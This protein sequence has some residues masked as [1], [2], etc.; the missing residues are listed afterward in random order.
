MYVYCVGISLHY[1]VCH[2][3]PEN[4]KKTSYI[5]LSTKIKLIK[6]SLIQQTEAALINPDKAKVDVRQRVT[7][8]RQR[9][10]DRSKASTCLSVLQYRM[11]E[12]EK[13]RAATRFS[14]SQHRKRDPQ[15]ARDATRLSVLEHY[16][17]NQEKSRTATRLRVSKHRERDPVKARAATR[18]NVSEHRKREPERAKVVSRLSVSAYRKRETEKSKIANRHD[19][20]RHYHRNL[21]K[22][23]SATR[24]KVM[25]YR[26]KYSDKCRNDN[27]HWVTTS[28]K[29]CL[30]KSRRKSRYSSK[31]FYRKKALTITKQRR[32]RYC[33]AE[34]RQQKVTCLLKSFQEIFYSKKKIRSQIMK[35]LE[36]LPSIKAKS[37]LA[38]NYGL[39]KLAASHL[40]RLSLLER[41]RA[42]NAPLQKKKAIN[43][44]ELGSEADFGERY[45]TSSRETYFYEA[46]YDYFE[47]CHSQSEGFTADKNPFKCKP[48]PNPIP[49]QENGKCHLSDISSCVKNMEIPGVDSKSQ[50]K[51]T[52][53]NQAQ[54][55]KWSCSSRCKTLS[56]NEIATIVSLKN[57]FD[58]DIP[59][60]RKELEECDKCPHVR[61]FKQEWHVLFNKEPI[62][63]KGLSNYLDLESED[64]SFRPV[65]RKGHPLACH[66]QG[67]SCES[68]LRVLTA[69][70]ADTTQN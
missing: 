17:K 57:V 30:Q 40:V 14:V 1:L 29:K 10:P 63:E 21:E 68:K 44:L 69:A 22:S 43:K 35:G 50:S 49:V 12:P 59:D 18:I 26:Q 46:A 15:K 70:V 38:T 5:I 45:H 53:D 37:G 9:N 28:Y 11:R 52:T 66:L 39:C 23:R 2:L 20:Y 51:E 54:T 58:N 55:N 65:E 42:A 47:D 6:N 62:Q 56:D 34:P 60:L 16:R 31:I 67:S 61:S 32:D 33:L 13:A 8:H 24:H 3:K 36:Y 48:L 19:A 27:R 41:K 4:A 7:E 25:T 64:K